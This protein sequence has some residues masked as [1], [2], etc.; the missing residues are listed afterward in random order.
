MDFGVGNFRKVHD[1]IK[2]IGRWLRDNVLPSGVARR[3]VRDTLSANKELAE[4]GYSKDL[5][6]WNRSNEYN[7][8]G[9]QMD[10][11]RQAGLNPN[12]VY[13]SGAVGNSSGQ[14]PKYSAPTADFS[15]VPPI[16]MG[17]PAMLGMFQDF[18]MKNAQIDNVRA[19]SESLRKFRNPLMSDQGLLT[20]TKQNREA[21]LS[22]TDYY[23]QEQM[24][25]LFPYQSEM[26]KEQVRNTQLRNE[27][28]VADNLYKRYTNEWRRM[29][30]TNSDHI[31]FRALIRAWME[32]GA[33]VPSMRSK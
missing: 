23:K 2:G 18:T 28:T 25:S 29:G 11:L 12:L 13:G 30:I 9:A 24:R 31:G 33:P 17:I 3:N 20:R 6:M 19:Q 32:S 15:R 4:Y 8:P 5:E 14:L 16:G 7:A 1:G 26:L 27:G 21:T 10:R 22:G